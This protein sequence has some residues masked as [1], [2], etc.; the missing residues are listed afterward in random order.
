MSEK[1]HLRI[2][3]AG[4]GTVGATVAQQILAGAIEGVSLS[5]VSARD[6]NKDRGFDISGLPFVTDPLDMVAD[7]TVDVLSLIHI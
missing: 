4:L 5:C 6:K 3:L 2:G 1:P 7:E